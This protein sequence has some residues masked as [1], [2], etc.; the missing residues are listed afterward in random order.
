[1]LLHYNIL[2][3]HAIYIFFYFPPL[4]TSFICVAG[5]A[6]FIHEDSASDTHELTPSQDFSQ[7]MNT[8]FVACV[9]LH[10]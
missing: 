1:M 4:T 10:L 5:Q 6:Y 9:R 2:N 7:E 8:A 3:I